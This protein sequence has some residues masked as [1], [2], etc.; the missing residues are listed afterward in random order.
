MRYILLTILALASFVNVLTAK[1]AEVKS[2]DRSIVFSVDISPEGRIVYSL[3]NGRKTTIDWSETGFAAGAD[4]APQALSL[5]ARGHKKVRVRQEWRPLWGKR[6]V[7]PDRYNGR[8]FTVDFPALG[9]A[10]LQVRV[11]DDGALAP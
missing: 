2:P 11:Y 4:A 10:T 8:D 1:P 3:S 5:D 7:V 9:T 6:S